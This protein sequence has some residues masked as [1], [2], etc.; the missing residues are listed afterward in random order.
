MASSGTLAYPSSAVVPVRGGS[1]LVTTPHTDPTIAS[2]EVAT[3]DSAGREIGRWPIDL[4]R[5][6]VWTE[7]TTR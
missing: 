3:F 5:E 6:D 4:P 1:A 2:Y 7:G